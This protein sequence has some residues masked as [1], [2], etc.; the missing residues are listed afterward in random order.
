MPASP[1]NHEEVL[2][3]KSAEILSMVEEYA[4][5]TERQTPE[6]PAQSAANARIEELLA[7]ILEQLRGMRKSEMFIAEFSLL[8][9]IA[10]VIQVFVPFCLLM[11]VWFLMG[12]TRHD[13]NTFV[14]LGFAIALQMMALTFYV[15]HGRR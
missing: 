3:T 6:G 14:A 15:M 4:K 5:E 13:N 11:A 1:T 10:G 8:R 9:L 12:T 7:G 2:A